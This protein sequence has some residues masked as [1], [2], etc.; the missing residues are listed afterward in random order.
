MKPTTPPELSDR[1]ATMEGELAGVRA[2]MGELKGTMRDVFNK[3]DGLSTRGQPSWQAIMAF[4]F[5]S[6]T[7][8]V[9]IATVVGVV[10]AMFVRQETSALSSEAQHTAQGLAHVAAHTQRLDDKFAA[11][12][13]EKIQEQKEDLHSLR[14]LIT[15]AR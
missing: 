7:A 4:G 6:I 2:D 1:V 3:L 12:R 9:T 15:G 8:F 14:D 11:L 13:E 10:I 5:S